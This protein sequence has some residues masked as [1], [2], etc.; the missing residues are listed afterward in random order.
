MSVMILAQL[1]VDDRTPESAVSSGLRLIGWAKTCG[2]DGVIIPKTAAG[3]TQALLQ[4]AGQVNLPCYREIESSDTLRVIEA[5]TGGETIKVFLSEG[6][7]GRAKANVGY[8]DT[9][10]HMWFAFNAVLA[11]ANPVVKGLTLNRSLGGP[12]HQNGLYPHEFEDLVLLSHEA[13]DSMDEALNAACTGVPRPARESTQ[14]VLKFGGSWVATRLL[15]KDTVIKSG[16]L[17]LIPE[18]KGISSA[19]DESS[20][21]GRR[22]FFDRA[23]DEP[24]TFGTL[25][26]LRGRSAGQPLNI[27]V[28][29]RAKNEARW[30]HQTLAA[31]I[32]QQRPPKQIIVV[33]NESTDDTPAIAHQFGCQVVP[34]TDREFSY[35]RALNLGIKAADSP[36]VVS[37][38]AH[39]VPVHDRW[40]E[41]FAQAP[42]SKSHTLAAVYGRQEPLPDTTDFDKRDLWTTFGEEA[43]IQAGQDYFFHN[44]NSLISRAAWSST[45]FDERLNG[46]EDR[47]WA[48]KMLADGWYIRY[49]P[50]ASVHHWHGIH[51][52]RNEA[53]A[54]RVVK[55]F[56]FIQQRDPTMAETR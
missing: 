6:P 47:A 36:W 41:A 44:A 37:L 45:D 27:S 2:A 8:T 31:L 42:L 1:L 55:M 17:K 15:K 14:E 13:L 46:M 49:E 25:D 5:G 23:V 33:D 10:P 24:V 50:L 3:C 43:R 18:L 39:C 52:G 32:H 4:K 21:I 19:I 34:I 56:E 26:P 7:R 20:L 28:V 30:L 54:K 29:I 40:L 53:R 48:R 51:Q 16:D 11:N 35:S 9:A 12:A 22:L 38:S